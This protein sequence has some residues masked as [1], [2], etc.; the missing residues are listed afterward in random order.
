MGV[1]GTGSAGSRGG[2]D[3]IQRPVGEGVNIFVKF[4][5]QVGHAAA[6]MLPVGDL[7]GGVYGEV[8]NFLR[9]LVAK[10]A[11]IRPPLRKNNAS[12]LHFLDFTL[13]FRDQFGPDFIQIHVRVLLEELFGTHE[14][15]QKY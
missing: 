14:R 2:Y 3:N 9:K 6:E 11:H 10:L 4:V 13:G 15:S 12:G 5:E 8:I 1:T 7:K